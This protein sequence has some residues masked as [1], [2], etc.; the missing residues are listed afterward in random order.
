MG[1]AWNR[2]LIMAGL[3]CALGGC[4]LASQPLAVALAGAGTSTAISQSLNGTAYRTFT[5][6][7]DEV[8]AAVLD[9]LSLMGIRVDSFQT[10]PHGEIVS[11]AA[12]ERTIEIELEPI[13][14]KA[15][16]VRVVAK[17]GAIFYDGATATEI[18]LQTE[19]TL[20]VYDGISAAGGSRRSYRYRR[21]GPPEG[22]SG[23]GR[24]GQRV[25]G[26]FLEGGRMRLAREQALEALDVAALV[27]RHLGGE[28]A[29]GVVVDMLGD[30]GVE[31][32][33]AALGGDGELQH[34]AGSA[35]LAD[36]FGG[37]AHVMPGVFPG[38]RLDEVGIRGAD[39]EQLVLLALLLADALELLGQVIHPGIAHAAREQLET[40]GRLALEDERVRIEVWEGAG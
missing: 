32:L 29:D 5:H 21:P 26:F 24:L 28:S 30:V 6:S 8:K 1:V 19:K 12:I 38:L 36:G 2:L 20:G 34:V 17:N 39:R 9:T 15:T 25:L 4:S 22:K 16:R 37:A 23:L 7:A 11:G 27:G 14:S 35:G 3:A 13:S 33:G 31:V 40:R 10:S 18:V